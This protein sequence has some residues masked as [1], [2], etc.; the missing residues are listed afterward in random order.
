M[1]RVKSLEINYSRTKSIGGQCLQTNTNRPLRSAVL[2]TALYKCFIES[3]NN[4]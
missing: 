3:S 1:D 4:K 2:N